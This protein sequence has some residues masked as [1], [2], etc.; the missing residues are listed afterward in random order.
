[1]ANRKGVVHQHDDA[2]PYTS[3]V[4]H[5]K[6][7]ELGWDVLSH[8]PYSPDIAPSDYHFLFCSMQNFLNGKIFNVDDGV[9][10]HLIQFFAGK[11]QNFYEH[12][13]MTLPERWQKVIDKNGQY[14]I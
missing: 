4:T 13:I 5:Q 9:N 11:N 8:P 7:L 12:E 2:K 14:L 10:S 6:L 1:M 3:L